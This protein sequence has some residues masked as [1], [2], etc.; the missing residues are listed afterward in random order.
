M[1]TK[2]L[3]TTLVGVGALGALGFSIFRAA[4]RMF[5]CL[6]HATSMLT[7]LTFSGKFTCIALVRSITTTRGS[8][9]SFHS[10]APYPVSIA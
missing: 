7:S 9:R 4:G 3:V 8:L 10:S 2:K 1:A 5:F 6:V